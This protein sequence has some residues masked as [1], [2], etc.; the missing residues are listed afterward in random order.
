MLF[1]ITEIIAAPDSGISDRSL[2]SASAVA[3]VTVIQDSP[4]PIVCKTKILYYISLFETLCF[5]KV[6]PQF[7][8]GCTIIF[9]SKKL[10][11]L[12]V[13]KKNDTYKIIFQTFRNR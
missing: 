7:N 2:S 5:L 12:H 8:H 1:D 4:L 13:Y 9:L 10:Y 11:T 6:K 3:G